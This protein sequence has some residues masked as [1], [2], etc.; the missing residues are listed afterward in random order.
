LNR[1]CHGTVNVRN[2]LKPKPKIR[3]GWVIDTAPSF[4]VNTSFA[5]VVHGRC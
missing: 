4:D 5:L 2:L 1:D 3:V